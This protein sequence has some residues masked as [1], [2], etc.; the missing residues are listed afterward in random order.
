MKIEYLYIENFRG[1]QRFEIDNLS[2][3]NVIA[4]VNGAGKTTII[5][6]LRILFS[7]LITRIRN[8]KSRGINISDS[9][10]T[11]GKKYCL[12][13]VRLDNG[14]GWQIYKQRSNYRG[15]AEHKT[16][17]SSMTPFANEIAERLE[18]TNDNADVTLIDAYGVNRVVDSTPMR[19]RKRHKLKP[20]DAMSVNMSNSVNFHD[21]F[22]WFREMED[23]EN[24]QLRNTGTLVPNS[25]L[26]AVRNA[27]SRVIDGYHNFRVQRNPQAFIIEKGDLK[28]DFNQLSDGEK[29]YIVLILDIA[30]KMAMTHPTME[31][32]LEGDGIVL[33]D[34]I[35]LHLHPTW[36]RDAVGKLQDLFPNCQFIITTHSPHVISCVNLSIGNKLVA[37]YDGEA[38]EVTGNQYG[39]E[40]DYILA[41][42]F[43][44]QSLRSPV[45]QKHIDTAWAMIRNKEF[46][47]ARFATEM[48]WLRNNMS[49]DDPIFAK[50]NLEMALQSKGVQA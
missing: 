34:E 47:S 15:P 5:S 33:I 18:S 28:L 44:M 39:R 2:N 36:Q 30:R 43:Q 50:I 13:K 26:E 25:K 1:I 37:I 4:G 40:S 11:K 42:I 20:M 21:F 27:I 3:L 7:W 22:I 19:V 16:D 38:T 8:A 49:C 6:A 17:M 35:D 48:E 45:A 29:S 23:I 31:N 24:E 12:L 14:V 46:G 41:D 10:I 9:D 32:P